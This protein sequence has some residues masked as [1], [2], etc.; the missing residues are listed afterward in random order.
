[1]AETERHRPG[2]TSGGRPNRSSLLGGE[3]RPSQLAEADAGSPVS[4]TPAGGWEIEIDF[5]NVPDAAWFGNEIIYLKNQVPDTSPSL[6]E[7][8]KREI[9]DRDPPKPFA[10]IMGRFLEY[11][12]FFADTALNFEHKGVG[13][14]HIRLPHGDYTDGPFTIACKLRGSGEFCLDLAID[15]D[16]AHDLLEYI[17]DATIHRLRVW[18]EHF[19]IDPYNFK[20]ADDFI[21]LLSEEHYREFVFPHHKRL[22]EALLP[23]DG[24]R[25]IHLC[26]DHS[27]FFPLLHK[28]LDVGIFDTGFPLDFG[29]VRAE[30]GQDV[31]I[32]G[33]PSIQLLQEGTV[34]EVQKET[35]RILESGIMDGGRFILRE[36][37]DLP[38]RTPM[39][40]TRTMYETVK[41]FGRYK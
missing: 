4:S 16:F 9:L 20:L 17:T 31:T 33:G 1:M 35:R 36:A 30:L 15:P 40:N 22:Y 21:L 37:S 19:P 11:Y 25:F 6:P 27:R 14:K 13:I 2:L 32:R 3:D 12:E 38:P 7:K 34:E 8:N 23:Q 10:G 29:R 39:K 24:Q 5:Q 41:Q 26:G 18:R 28:E